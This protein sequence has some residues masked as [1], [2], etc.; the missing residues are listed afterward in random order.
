MAITPQ[1]IRDRFPEFDDVAAYPD[2]RI[3][4]WIDKGVGEL[5]VVAWGDQYDEG[6]LFFVAHFLAWSTMMTSSGGAA[7]S[8]GPVA[9]KSVGDV[10]ISFASVVGPTASPTESFYSSTAYGQEYWRLVQMYGVGMLAV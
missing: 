7:G 5:S 1:D 8:V 4:T 9:S 10:S 6:L 2:A 3:Q